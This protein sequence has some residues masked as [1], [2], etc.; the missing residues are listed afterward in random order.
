MIIDDNLKKIKTLGIGQYSKVYEV[1]DPTDDEVYALK[2][3]YTFAKF[4]GCSNIR[5]VDILARVRGHPF[6]ININK[7]FF[8]NPFSPENPITPN[9]NK[10]GAMKHDI[11][12]FTLEKV[13]INL[14]T[15]LDNFTKDHYYYVRIKLFITQLLIAIDYLHREGIVHRDIKPQNLL[16][17]ENQDNKEE[18]CI[19]DVLKVSDFGLSLNMSNNAPSTPGTVTSWYRAPEIAMNMQYG[20][21]SDMWSIGCVIY[22]MLTGVPLLSGVSDSQIDVYSNILGIVDVDSETLDSMWQNSM[23][24]RYYISA[25]RSRKKWY[26]FNFKDREIFDAA[27]LGGTTKE[28]MDVLSKLLIFDPDKRYDTRG[29]LQMPFFEKNRNYINS[30]ICPTSDPN[31]KMNLVLNQE[32]YLMGNIAKHNIFNQRNKIP[33]YKHRILFHAIELFDRYMYWAYISHNSIPGAIVNDQYIKIHQET[34]QIVKRFC[35]CLYVSYKYFASLDVP[36]YSWGEFI[37]FI[38]GNL[39]KEVEFAREF[40]IIL[41]EHVTRYLI[42]SPTVFEYLP[43]SKS[44]VIAAY[45]NIYASLKKHRETV[46]T[47]NLFSLIKH[48]EGVIKI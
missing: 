8:D 35:V 26:D 23:T 11:I 30:N 18:N 12:H 45:L 17:L 10:E 3:N 46:V 5:E 28:L 7:V 47:L 44:E 37:K 25:T 6:I 13:D 16:L 19:S 33:W 15:Y 29:V 14:K 20:T 48:I 32:R 9:N 36:D 43:N 2:H 22:E 21:E 1:N 39:V 41:L 34:S 27:E 38:N 24:D 4:D 31:V 40:E 42:Y